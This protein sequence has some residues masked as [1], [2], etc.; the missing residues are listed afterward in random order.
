MLAAV[1]ICCP[2]A[3]VSSAAAWY[4]RT[5]TCL[6]P[7]C[8]CVLLRF[9][10]RRQAAALPAVCRYASAGARSLTIIFRV[11]GLSSPACT[12]AHPHNHARKH[13]QILRHAHKLT[14]AHI[15]SAGLDRPAQGGC[16]RTR[17][18][19]AIAP[20]CPGT[21]VQVPQQC[22]VTYLLARAHS[23]T[24]SSSCES[25]KSSANP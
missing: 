3:P 1:C 15:R 16:T 13:I 23:P 11:V 9:H 10:K 14:R 6:L 18:S 20:V 2:C 24:T 7:V 22:A 17:V 5:R 8:Q 12:R 25:R 4:T 21:A 19:P